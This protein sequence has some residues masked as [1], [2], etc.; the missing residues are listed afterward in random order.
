M[1]NLFPNGYHLKNCVGNAMTMP[2]EIPDGATLLGTLAGSAAS[3][4][5]FALAFRKRLWKDKVEVTR[6]AAEVNIIEALQE[7]RDKLIKEL[8]ESRE[9][10]RDAWAL[11]AEASKL[12][13]ELSAQVKQQTK[14]IELLETRVES[15]RKDVHWLRNQLY[16]EK[17]KEDLDKLQGGSDGR[18]D[19]HV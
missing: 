11:R 10:E 19:D 16:G 5:A 15:L 18:S 1:Y 13:G 3:I 17:L 7:E 6:D 14:V 4:A 9:R 8:D 2:P 12:I